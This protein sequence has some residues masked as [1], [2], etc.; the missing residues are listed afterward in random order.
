MSSLKNK[1]VHGIMWS[2]IDNFSSQGITFIVGIILARLLSPEEFGLIGMLTIFIAVSESF[3][4]SGF[5]QALIRKKDCSE[6]D[7]STVFYFNLA[8]GILFF[9]IL[10]TFSPLIGRFFN[11]PQLKSILRVL[12]LVLI[13]D[14]LT[15]IQRTTLTKRVDFKLQT[16]ISV[17][18]AIT[19]GIIGIAMAYSGYGVW[20]LIF[21]TLSQRMV[22]SLLLWFWNRWRPL[23]VFSIQSFKELFSFGSKLLLSGLIDTA[24]RNIYYLVI[25]KYFSASELGYYTRA[26]NFKD[27]PSSNLNGIMSRVT[28]PVLAQMQDDPVKLKS[29]YKKMIKSIM[30]ISMVLMAG[31]A[32]VAEP[33][34]ITLIGEKWRPSIIYLQLLTFVG[35]MYPLHSLNLNML[36]VQ[37]R[38]DLF[39]RLEIIKKI[40]AIPTIIIGVLFGIKVMILGMWVNTLIA[41]Y[42]NSYWSGKMIN[43]PMSEQI[44][45]IL[46]GFMIAV[47]MGALVMLSGRVIPLTYFLKLIIQLIIGGVFA[48]FLCEIFKPE[49]YLE[50][51]QI[52]QNTIFKRIHG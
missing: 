26:Q 12:S 18:A 34:I 44:N 7:Y 23:L 19:S 47:A 1:T 37:G 4:N 40:I 9:L 46:P 22:N 48:L 42:L 21:K 3:I 14:S 11:E 24:Y 32:A 39:L 15:I 27:L 51:R 52:A 50:L 8:A 45:D 29:G 5:S 28:Y 2:A 49:A 35:M 16:K 25:G 30:L 33:M 6:T 36:Q 13:I 17:I 41:Y 38:S 20:S 31:L 43:Y 10:F